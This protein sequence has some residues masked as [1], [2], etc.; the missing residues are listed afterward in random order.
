MSHALSGATDL[1]MFGVRCN[2]SF[3][4]HLNSEILLNSF[5][6]SGVHSV[7]ASKFAFAGTAFLLQ[8]VAGM[9]MANAHFAVLGDF[10]A[11]FSTAMGF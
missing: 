4:S 11:V 8:E 9:G 10:Y 5:G 3:D 6:I 7:E 1:R 2:A